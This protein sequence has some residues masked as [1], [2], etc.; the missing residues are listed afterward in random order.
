[1]SLYF[2]VNIPGEWGIEE[3]EGNGYVTRIALNMGIV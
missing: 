3:T 1:M 2:L